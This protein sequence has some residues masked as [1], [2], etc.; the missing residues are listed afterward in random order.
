MANQQTHDHEPAK[1]R[2]EAKWAA[3]INDQLF[4]L[5]RRKR[6]ARD[7]LDQA[8]VAKEFV[9]VRDHDN[10]NDVVLEDE[11]VVDLAG[12]NV[13]RTMPRCEAGPQRPCAVADKRGNVPGQSKI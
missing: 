8:G 13:F 9:L 11:K 7:I 4:P 12:G 6:A 10:P 3:I 5:A 1:H 2:A